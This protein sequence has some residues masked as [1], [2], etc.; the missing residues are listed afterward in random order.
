MHLL[1]HTNI[2]RSFPP[3]D[4]T[5][6]DEIDPVTGLSKESMTAIDLI[7]SCDNEELRRF[8]APLLANHTISIGQQIEIYYR[9]GESAEHRRQRKEKTM[10]GKRTSVAEEVAAV[11]AFWRKAKVVD[12]S[13]E[14]E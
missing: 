8:N 1:R 13:T 4:T 2:T 14:K 7:D 5:N 3:D 11:V 9:I 10:T 12:E 6:W